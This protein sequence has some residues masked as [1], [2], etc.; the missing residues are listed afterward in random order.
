MENNKTTVNLKCKI[1]KALYF[2]ASY[3]WKYI[4]EPMQTSVPF[5]LSSGLL[6]GFSFCNI[7]I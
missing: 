4:R 3:W 7:Y 2:S 5:I 6:S 1:N